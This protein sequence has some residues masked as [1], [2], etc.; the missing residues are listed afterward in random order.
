[1]SSTID[2]DIGYIKAKL[3]D[4]KE[5]IKALALMLEDH[6][7]KEEMHLQE[8]RESIE[9]VKDELTIYKTIVKTLKAVAGITIAIL[10]WKFGDIPGLLRGD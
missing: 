7:R 3:E 4:N 1:M 5:D 6:A 2:E 10:T 9:H 8:L